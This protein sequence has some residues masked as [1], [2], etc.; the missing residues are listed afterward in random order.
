MSRRG[1]LRIALLLAVILSGAGCSYLQDRGKDFL[2]IWHI[3]I[4]VGV[5]LGI[6]FQL[7]DAVHSGLAFGVVPRGGLSYGKK[8]SGLWIGGAYLIQRGYMRMDDGGGD[9]V[10]WQGTL[11][12]FLYL[13]KYFD[14]KY[15]NQPPEFDTQPLIKNRMVPWIHMF[16]VDVG[17]MAIFASRIGVSP[18]QAADF[19]LGW[20]GLDIAKDDKIRDKDGIVA[21]LKILDKSPYD[22]KANYR[23]AI[24]YILMKDHA[25]AI[26][27]FEIARCV[28]PDD[29]QMLYSL[30]YAYY[31]DGQREKALEALEAS[32]AAGLTDEKHLEQDPDLAPLRKDPFFHGLKERLHEMDEVEGDAD[33]EDEGVR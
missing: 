2:D 4:G 21:F 26:Y 17:V 1:R 15:C 22:F 27:H 29:E 16:D 14:E 33:S 9:R 30:A 8:Q 12:N 7:T 3:D 13:P 24:A 10:S 31:L 25:M 20:F 23:I 5:C 19:L 28:K 6:D 18:G 32:R 11:W